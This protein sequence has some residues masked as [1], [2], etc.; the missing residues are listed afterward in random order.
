M[1]ELWGGIT[2]LSVRRMTILKP[3]TRKSAT[4]PGYESWEFY[5]VHDPKPETEDV[6]SDEIG[7]KDTKSSR[8]RYWTVYEKSTST[9]DRHGLAAMHGRTL[10]EA[11]EA[12]AFWLDGQAMPRVSGGG[13]KWLR[14]RADA[15]G[16]KQWEAA[17]TVEVG[18]WELQEEPL[19]MEA[20]GEYG[21]ETNEETLKC[22]R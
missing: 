20:P 19:L 10:K 6:A 22:T 21:H 3:Q 11:C 1:S 18:D 4:I 2:C 14:E 9:P 12:T 8:K 16:A 17:M 13:E 15:W 5:G 7:I